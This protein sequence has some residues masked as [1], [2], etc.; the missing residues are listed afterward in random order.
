MHKIIPKVLL[1]SLT[2]REVILLST[3]EVHSVYG[4][5]RTFVLLVSL[6]F[7]I[8]YAEL[9]FFAHQAWRAR[10]DGE[11][12]LVVGGAFA[13]T[14]IAFLTSFALSRAYSV[15]GAEQMGS[16]VLPELTAQLGKGIAFILADTLICFFLYLYLTAFDLTAATTLLNNLYVFMLAGVL[17]HVIVGYVRYGAFLYAVNQDSYVKVLVVS[18]GLGMLIFAAFVYL[19]NLD[20]AWLAQVPAAQRGLYSLH[21]YARDLYFFSLILGIYAW[22]ARWMA[23]H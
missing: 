11:A 16:L 2:I 21:V 13:L 14:L 4:K 15:P 9:G 3:P 6:A 20:I 7:A 8:L 17:L 19:I 18:G 10:G 22:H 1:A 12:A 23:D 5:Y